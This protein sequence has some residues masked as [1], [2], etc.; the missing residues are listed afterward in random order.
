MIPAKD[1]FCLTANEQTELRLIGLHHSG[2]LFK[3]FDDN[4]EYL[5]RWHPWVDHL[6]SVPAVERAIASWQKLYATKKAFHAGIWFNGQFCGMISYLNVDTTNH[7]TPMCY[8]LDEAHQGKGIMTACCRAMIA[9]G[10][11]AWG[12]NRFTIE[13]A[14]ENSRSRAI[15]ERLGFKLEGIVRGIQWLQDHYVDAAMYGLLRSDFD[16]IRSLNASEWSAPARSVNQQGPSLAALD[17]W[18]HLSPWTARLCR[19]A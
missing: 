16:G 3:L 13:C 11:A 1:I 19:A 18:G 2:E 4:R 10:F 8:W 17:R 7:W 15:A 9:H 6:R 12:L 14:S 5:R